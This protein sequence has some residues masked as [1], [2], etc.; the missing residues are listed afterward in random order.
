MVFMVKQ[1]FRM[2]QNQQSIILRWTT[3]SCLN[4]RME[5]QFSTTCSQRNRYQLYYCQLEYRTLNYVILLHCTMLQVSQLMHQCHRK[6]IL[7]IAFISLLFFLS[8]LLTVHVFTYLF[9]Y[10][11]DTESII[12]EVTL[13]F[14]TNCCCQTLQVLIYEYNSMLLCVQVV[15]HQILVYL[16]TEIL[17][18]T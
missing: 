2:D 5:W 3:V 11:L 16:Q 10:L 7:R 1:L 14:R 4:S 9:C 17:C 8:S 13:R 18:H 6:R 15:L 12:H